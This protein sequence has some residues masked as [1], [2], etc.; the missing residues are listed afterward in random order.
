[1]FV[2]NLTAAWETALIKAL[3]VIQRVSSAGFFPVITRF[4]PTQKTSN[5]NV[6][7]DPISMTTRFYSISQHKNNQD[8][9][10]Y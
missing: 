10:C 6:K 7:L 2:S 4:T 8:L 3:R 5:E 9:A 1:M